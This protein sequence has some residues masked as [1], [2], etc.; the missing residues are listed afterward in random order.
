[1][2]TLRFLFCLLLLLA[3]AAVAPQMQAQ[4]GDCPE[5]QT[6]EPSDYEVIGVSIIFTPLDT[7]IS[8]Y[9]ATLL[10][11]AVAA[12]YN[13]GGQTSLYG[14]ASYVPITSGYL[15]DDGSGTAEGWLSTSEVYGQYYLGTEHWL[16]AQVEEDLYVDP[17]DFSQAAGS[18][19]QQD[20]LDVY[21]NA[22][23]G[24]GYPVMQEPEIQVGS[25]YDVVA[26]VPP[27]ISSIT[28]QGN[29]GSEVPEVTLNSS[30]ILLDIHGASLTDGGNDPNPAVCVNGICSGNGGQV[31]AAGITLNV[32]A[33]GDADITVNCSVDG[34]ASSVGTH[35]IT[36]VTD[37]GTSN[38]V[39]LTVGDP[40]PVISVS[41]ASP[42]QAAN[43]P[44]LVTVTGTGFGTN[45]QLSIAGTA[46]AGVTG[47]TNHPSSGP[48]TSITATVTLY[49]S[50]GVAA[51]TVASQG[52]GGAGPAGF[53]P[54]YPN[55]PSSAEADVAV[56][57]APTAP[58]PT[59]V[60]G[61]G[62]G[63]CQQPAAVP[64]LVV[65]QLTTITGCLPATVPAGNVLNQYWSY[66]AAFIQNV[67]AGYN[68]SASNNQQVSYLSL[69]IGCD[70]S[71]ISCSFPAF[72]P[73]SP[74]SPG[75]YTLT[76]TYVLK[77]S[78]GS[79]SISVALQVAGP[80][81]ASIAA[82][83]DNA[84][85]VNVG[86]GTAWGLPWIL[87]FGIAGVV[88][89]TPGMTF[90]ASATLPAGNQGQYSWIQLLDKDS[91]HL[92]DPTN[93]P[94]ACS[95]D[96]SPEYDGVYNPNPGVTTVDS[97]FTS[98]Y[99]GNGNSRGELARSFQASMYLM[100]QPNPA[101]GCDSDACTILVP[102]AEVDWSWTG[103]TINTVP[104][105]AG[106]SPGVWPLT[107][108]QTYSPK[109]ASTATSSYPKWGAFTGN[110]GLACSKMQ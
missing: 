105:Q 69:P 75:P 59:V 11:S 4:S 44:L 104:K 1:M 34:Q 18:N 32:T 63:A 28:E 55:E 13:A 41:P 103:D 6:C 49:A 40:T 38:A 12:F 73:I 91:V 39:G 45:P 58:L 110:E 109:P 77:N 70:P 27:V 107:G 9:S 79:G 23:E 60:W 51:I 14:G 90:T 76:Y 46:V 102:L 88:G 17:L 3:Q 33:V 86:A 5:G 93:G 31:S 42:W 99:D 72:Y 7:P 47:V 37:A 71:Q 19:P 21:G 81:G 98:L 20:Y 30:G 53:L 52:Y 97:P 82:V 26:R 48:V 15:S 94:E 67:V 8:T 92:I 35:S 96:V 61:Q 101:P 25:S 54:G 74:G 85:G 66:P 64:P 62:A 80:T 106:G 89:G 24:D 68:P 108:C 84:D 56:A 43:S 95:L 22:S 29:S 83:P 10:G 50:G 16:I 100:W 87:Q 65:G 36:V 78:A 2:N 57:P